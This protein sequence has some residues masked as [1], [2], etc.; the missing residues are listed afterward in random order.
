MDLKEKTVLISLDQQTLVYFDKFHEK[1]EG[2]GV[3]VCLHSN[4]PTDIGLVAPS[5]SLAKFIPYEGNLTSQQFQILTTY[6][7]GKRGQNA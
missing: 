2:K 5:F 3:G 6:S 7:Q 4:F 1:Q